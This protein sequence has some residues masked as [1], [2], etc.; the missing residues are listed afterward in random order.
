MALDIKITKR[1]VVERPHVIKITLRSHKGGMPTVKN[2]AKRLLRETG[3][4]ISSIGLPSMFPGR[5]RGS[6]A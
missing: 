3:A 2:S 6:S 1:H 4:I 5:A